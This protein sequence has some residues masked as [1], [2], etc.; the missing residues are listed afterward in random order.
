MPVVRIVI[1]TNVFVSGLNFG[2]IPW[3]VVE[4]MQLGLV[5]VAVSPFILEEIRRVLTTRFSWNPETIDDA[6]QLILARARLV[7]PSIRL[8]VIT[9]KDSDNRIL[10]CA[11]E[12][13]AQYLI[14]G[15]KRH[16]LR[17]GEYEG[18]QIVSPADFL[19]L[20]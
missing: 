13:R 4:Q 15:D 7:E 9:R 8:S 5:D 19:N 11:V 6:L 10:E 14:S 16:L 20:L 2:G 17:L 3:Q 1:D 18:I 12:S